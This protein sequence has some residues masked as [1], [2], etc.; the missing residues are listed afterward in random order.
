MGSLRTASYFRLLH[1]NEIA[2]ACLFSD[3]GPGAKARE[4]ANCCSVPDYAVFDY[5]RVPN[6]NVVADLDVL[7]PRPRLNS[8]TGTDSA[9]ALDYDLRVYH[10]VLPN[11]NILMNVSGCRVH[12]RNSREHQLAKLAFAQLTFQIGEFDSR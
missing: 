9:G 1:L 10:R 2:N 7:D 11:L 4:W 12:D 3:V 8:A 6:G 5:T